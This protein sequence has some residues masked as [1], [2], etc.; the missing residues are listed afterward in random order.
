MSSRAT[1]CFLLF[2]LPALLAGCP[3][4]NGRAPSSTPAGPVADP[5][6]MDHHSVV[7]RTEAV[8]LSGL[9]Q[10]PDGKL[11]VVPER[12]RLLIPVLATGQVE[13]AVPLN[14]IPEGVDTEAMAWLDRGRVALGLE[15]TSQG[16]VMIQ[17]VRCDVAIMAWNEKDRAFDLAQ[18]LALPMKRW[19]LTPRPNRGVEGLCSAGDLL[20]ASLETVLDRDGVR[21]APLGVYDLKRGTWQA[22]ALALSSS[23]AQK[24]K[25]SALHCDLA[26]APAE[27]LRLLSV[28][29]HFD[30]RRLVSY[31]V[32]PRATQPPLLPTV[33]ADLAV[34]GIKGDNP[35]GLVRMKSGRWAVI[36]DNHYGRQMGLSYLSFLKLPSL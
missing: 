20:A 34:M 28:E 9:A 10:A 17:G 8:G 24:G 21:A 32:P 1:L 2:F 14:G 27:G 25:I 31:A 12:Q 13:P 5:K 7:I 26:A 33:V 29:R 22:H 15:S 4:G 18:C 23:A 6:L 30:V 16:L 3:V 35:E 19:D 11:W 36:N